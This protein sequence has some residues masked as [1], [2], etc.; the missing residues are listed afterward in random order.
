MGE[1][2]F[3]ILKEYGFPTLVACTLGYWVHHLDQQATVERAAY[4]KLIYENVADL[5]ADIELTKTAC[6]V[7]SV[8][9]VR[10]TADLALKEV[11]PK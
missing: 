4:T 8:P 11:L 3:R 6:G 9:K 7:I 1:L 5:Q 2:G 10:K